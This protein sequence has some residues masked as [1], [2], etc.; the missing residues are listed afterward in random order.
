MSKAYGRQGAYILIYKETGIKVW[1]EKMTC[2]REKNVVKILKNT[3]RNYKMN[4]KMQL[5]YQ[6]L[7]ND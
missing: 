6:S 2:N 1:E 5:L 4:W 3:T 7:K